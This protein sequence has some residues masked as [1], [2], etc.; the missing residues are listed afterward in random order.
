VAVQHLDVAYYGTNKAMA[1]WSEN[2]RPA[3]EIASL[4]PT[5]GM[6]GRQFREIVR[7]QRLRYAYWDG[8]V[9]SAPA[10]L[11]SGGSDGKPQLAGC[12]N[13]QQ[14]GVASCPSAGEITAVWERD[15]NQN[16]D[17]P[18]LEV[19]SARWTRSGGW[20]SA[21]RVSSTG[22]SSDML[23]SVAYRAD[24][25]VVAWARNP[26]GTFADLNR[27]H[28]SYRFLNGSA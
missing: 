14:I 25:A 27:R 23:P 21:L 1:V 22:L 6:R 12:L 28:I 9:W 8:S 2:S 7:S 13:N 3:S 16:L 17:A 15:A 24:V 18:D 26:G 5:L 19:W 20:T 4:F 10:D 11:T